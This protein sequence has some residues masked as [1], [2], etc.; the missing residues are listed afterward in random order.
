MRKKHSDN[1]RFGDSGNRFDGKPYGTTSRSGARPLA[2]ALKRGVIHCKRCGTRIVSGLEN[3]PFCGQSLQPFYKRIWF[4]LI[5]IVL[6]GAGV[7]YLLV[8]GLP[9][10]LEPIERDYTSE[11]HVVDAAEGASYRDLPIGTAVQ[12]DM[13]EAC[14]N[15]VVAGPQTAEGTA[16]VAVHMRI[17]NSSQNSITLYSTQW[18]IENADGTRVD[19]YLGPSK[20]GAPLSSSFETSELLPD[21]T[22][23]GT[24]Y[25]ATNTP[26]LVLYQPNA[27]D[28]REEI[29][30]TWTL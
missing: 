9:R 29:L 25:F 17:T 24:L 3:C 26:K 8:V 28:F 27:L 12:S 4:W 6:L 19:T 5:I 7:A 2:P 16:T 18:R 21:Q 14:V 1:W 13:I 11:I 30:V 10:N 22:L 20:T 15:A 23:D